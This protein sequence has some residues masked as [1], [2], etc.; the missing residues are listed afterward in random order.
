MIFFTVRIAR[1]LFFMLVFLPPLSVQAQFADIAAP[2]P[3]PPPAK[4]SFADGRMVAEGISSAYQAI[5]PIEGAAIRFSG[6]LGAEVEFRFIDSAGNSSGWLP[7]VISAEPF[8][9]RTIAGYRG[10]EAEGSVRFEYRIRADTEITILNTGLFL[11]DEERYPIVETAPRPRVATVPKPRIISRE[12]W[13]ARPPKYSYTNHPYFDKLTQHHAAGYKATTIEQGKQ[14]MRAIQ[15][16]HQNVRGWNDIGYHF[17]VDR[18]GNIYQGRPETVI[19]AHVGGANTGNIG[20][21]VLGCYH[22]PETSYYCKDE[23]TPASM[24]SLVKL[25]AWISETYGYNPQVL[26]G[27]RDYFGTTACPGDNIHKLL[28]EMRVDIADYIEN[29][30][31]PAIPEIFTLHQNFPNPFNPGTK[32]VYTL[33]EAGEVTILIV[34]VNGRRVR[35]IYPGRQEKGLQGAYWDG[36]DSAGRQAA[37]GIY[38]ARVQF[39]GQVKA[40]Q[41]LLLR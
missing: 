35:E 31:K 9:D 27:H 28:P 40:Q 24:D 4:I 10:A 16:L 11:R 39:N 1:T 2:L 32:I 26:L 25:F 38:F 13:G 36:R 15:D 29:A 41:M 6:S 23:L 17:V 8:S 3:S 20:V 14:Q 18:S 21:C 30:G 33:P 12:E 7:G 22:P 34:D 5:R 37:T 19:G